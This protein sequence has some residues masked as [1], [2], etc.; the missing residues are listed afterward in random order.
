MNMYSLI[1]NAFKLLFIVKNM[2]KSLSHCNSTDSGEFICQ[3]HICRDT[4]FVLLPSFAV[5][6][7]CI[8]FLEPEPLHSNWLDASAY[9][10]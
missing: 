3:S 9:W 7:V 10:A 2:E 8:L 6:V 1:T 5:E 4:W